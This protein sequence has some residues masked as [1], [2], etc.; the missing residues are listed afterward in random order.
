[1][2]KS[3]PHASGCRVL[4]PRGESTV[5]DSGPRS[6]IVA[7]PTARRPAASSAAGDRPEPLLE[8]DARVRVEDPRPEVRVVGL[9]QSSRLK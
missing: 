8:E 2:R 1:M 4:P 9:D 3:R 6:G 5:I 7:W